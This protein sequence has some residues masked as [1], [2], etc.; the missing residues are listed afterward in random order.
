MFVKLL[1]NELFD[2]LYTEIVFKFEK[3]N[4]IKKMVRI[5]FS[6]LLMNILCS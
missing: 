4:G 5:L 1:E 2:I 6:S 3:Y